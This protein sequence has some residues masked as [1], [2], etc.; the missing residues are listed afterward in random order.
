MPREVR[1]HVRG[2]T[3]NEGWVSD[4]SPNDLTPEPMLRNCSSC[5]F[6]SSRC[7]DLLL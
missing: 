7:P 6:C 2:N 5:H 1:Q 4:V 3:A